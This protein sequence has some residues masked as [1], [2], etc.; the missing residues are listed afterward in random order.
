MDDQLDQ[1]LEGTNLPSP[2]MRRAI[3]EQAGLSLEELA[4]VIGVARNT[5]WRWEKGLHRPHPGH[6]RTYAGVLRQV[7]EVA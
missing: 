1:L 4:D 5:L 2:V 6:R 3:R 7:N